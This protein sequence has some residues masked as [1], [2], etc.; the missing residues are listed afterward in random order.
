MSSP[1]ITIERLDGAGTISVGNA[2]ELVR[3]FAE[4]DRGIGY[5]RSIRSS[6]KDRIVAGDIEVL[7]R[8]MRT[9]SSYEHWRGL[10][11]DPKPA[12]LGALPVSWDLSAITKEQWTR[13]CGQARM[14][15][16]FAAMLGPYR[17]LSVVSK[18]LHPKRPKLI[19]ILDA[20]VLE[21]LGA[22]A[23]SQAPT[24]TKAHVAGQ[25]VSHLRV[26]ARANQLALTTLQAGLAR[27]GIGLSRI[28]LIDILLWMTHPAVRL[29]PFDRRMT[30]AI[31]DSVAQQNSSR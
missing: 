1:V 14:E 4:L 29:V 10:I 13:R 6:P 28:R 3:R 22:Q 24:A 27:Q 5:D 31:M 8:S 26:Q 9:G 2:A 18:V 30:I 15:A 16:A 7:N 25:V 12:W 23:R 17:G 19:P 21:Q 20:L 11:G